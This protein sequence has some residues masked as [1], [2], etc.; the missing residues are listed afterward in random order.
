VDI[1][2]GLIN[3]I[4]SIKTALV[5]QKE[6]SVHFRSSYLSLTTSLRAAAINAELLQGLTKWDRD[7]IYREKSITLN[8]EYV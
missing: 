1:A 6:Q 3:N 7:V 4:A 8:V 2:Q 5:Q